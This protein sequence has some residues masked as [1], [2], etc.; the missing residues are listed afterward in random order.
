MNLGGL[1]KWTVCGLWCVVC[2]LILDN[3]NIAYIV[4]SSTSFNVSGDRRPE[5]KNS[6]FPL[7]VN[8]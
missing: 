4:T 1:V 6:T 3:S 8:R 5:L 2:G 7:T